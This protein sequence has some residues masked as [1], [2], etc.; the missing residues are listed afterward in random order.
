MREFAGVGAVCCWLLYLTHRALHY[1]FNPD[2]EMNL[3]FALRAP[4]R[5]VQSIPVFWNGYIRPLGNTFY[6]VLYRSFGYWAAPFR[7]ASFALI[8]LNLL[9]LYRLF[10]TLTRNRNAALLAILMGCFHPEMWDIFAS[11]GTVYDVL[12]QTFV[13]LALLL[14]TQ[15]KQQAA[16]IGL[17]T[18]AAVD[19]KEIGVTIPA[20]LLAYDAIFRPKSIRYLGIAA[21]GIVVVIFLAGRFAQSTALTGHSEY[22]PIFS[23]LQWVATTQGYLN[24]LLLKPGISQFGAALVLG[25]SLLLALVLRNRLMIFGLTFYLLA[26]LPMSFV[27]MRAGYALYI[28]QTGAV[29]FVIAFLLSLKN[30]LPAPSRPVRVAALGL[31]ALTIMAA[32]FIGNRKLREAQ[33]SPAYLRELEVFSN[34]MRRD[35]PQ[36]ATQSKITLINDPFPDDAIPLFTLV[37]LYNDP[38]VTVHRLHWDPALG[39]EQVEGDQNILFF[40]GLHCWKLGSR[41]ESGQIIDGRPRAAVSMSSPLAAW[42]IISGI[43]N[44]PGPDGRRWAFADPQLVFPRPSRPSELRF[45]YDV[46]GAVMEQTGP[47]RVT[48]T[49]DESKPEPII[50]PTPGSRTYNAPIA[51]TGN[52]LVHVKIHVEN[53]Y[54]GNDG[55]K[56]SFF[57]SWAGLL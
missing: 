11:T 26:L 35:F 47:L 8:L 23:G 31:L 34:S 40:A 6:L 22:T 48:F 5:T 54:R 27:S 42:N 18:V 21:S 55:A 14:W 16:L 9:L 2:D 56:L 19:A 33:I 43:A 30:K 32:Q 12:C 38:S 7:A 45:L 25:V 49:V 4:L 17:V 13:L 20:I 39:L 36:L 24:L 44:E 1:G 52:P 15:K 50:I 57:V 41:D 10:K 46:P 53:P 29:L 28:P 51:A 37:D 3:F